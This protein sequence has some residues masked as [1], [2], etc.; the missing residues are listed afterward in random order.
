MEGKVARFTISPS[1]ADSPDLAECG[2]SA[3]V[4][5][6]KK[7]DASLLFKPIAAAPLTLNSVNAVASAS[8]A[9]PGSSSPTPM[10]LSGKELEE[11]TMK[12]VTATTTTTTAATATATT[13]TT[14]VPGM[15]VENPE[16]ANKADDESDDDEAE[17]VEESPTGRW[18][19]RKEQIKY[20][21]VPGI[22]TAYL[23][24]DSEEGFEVVWNE[25]QFSTAKKFASQE[26]KLKGV[27]EA[28][29]LIDHPNIVRFHNYWIDKGN[30]NE[31][32]A[33]RLVFITEYMSSGSL[34]NFLRKTKKNNRKIALQS[35]KRWCTQILSALSYLHQTCTPPIIHG[36]LTCDT[37]FIQHNGLVKIGS[38]APDI[39]H[40][41]VKTCRE[42]IK[43]LHYLAPE[44]GEEGVIPDTASDIYSFG[45]CALET[46]ALDIQPSTPQVTSSNAASSATSAGGSN[47]STNIQGASTTSNPSSG[48][49]TSASTIGLS[50]KVE[51]KEPPPK[52]AN[53]SGSSGTTSENHGA[54]TG[55]VITEEM[56]FRAIDHL[57]DEMQKDFI[58]KCMNKDP[59]A[60][61]T[62]RDL[63]FHPVLF[64]VHSLK[65]LAAHSLVNAPGNIN[66][67]MDDDATKAHYSSQTVKAA[68]LKSGEQKEFKL[69]DFPVAEKLEKFMEDVKNGI[70]PI[71][72]FPLLQGASAAPKTRACSPENV[73]DEKRNLGTPEPE[74]G[75]VNNPKMLNQI[76]VAVGFGDNEGVDP[77]KFHVVCVGKCEDGIFRQVHAPLDFSIHTPGVLAEE[78]IAQRYYVL[79]NVGALSA[80]FA[81]GIRRFAQLVATLALGE[82][83]EIE[84][85][86][87]GEEVLELRTQE[88]YRAI[89]NGFTWYDTDHPEQTKREEAY[90]PEFVKNHRDAFNITL[91][92][93]MPEGMQWLPPFTEDAE[94]LMQQNEVPQN[95][96]A[97][98][99][100]HLSE[101]Q[102]YEMI[103]QNYGFVPYGAR[104]L[105]PPNNDD[106]APS[107]TPQ[108]T[109][110]DRTSD[111]SRVKISIS[112]TNSWRSSP[113]L[114]ICAGEAPF[115]ELILL[116]PLSESRISM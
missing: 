22:D 17:I 50:E 21:D 57:D 18:L 38:I 42:N 37:I 41:N 40:Q 98:D 62:A 95:I 111:N 47:T 68:V 94:F 8:T 51:G 45:V 87:F 32:K 48:S 19:K 79:D 2:A 65:L 88:Q 91:Q 116:F 71:T 60:R 72:A 23:A 55:G 54:T 108:N 90:D 13:T 97:F 78:L 86:E 67:T 34:K 59:K 113:C 109:D 85:G 36:N 20:R 58:R 53:P 10:A 93:P 6:E 106:S 56:L 99:Y 49:S 27:F 12:Q 75:E 92:Y 84:E 15:G 3:P 104:N 105:P 61:P 11:E 70:Y 76:L 35:W 63:L 39:I 89:L 25:A 80:A 73:V 81:D 69:S 102:L 24:M 26:E 52:G 64:E 83:P 101:D 66:E 100:R 107:F 96:N 114:I 31:K 46:A 30:P 82:P 44:W 5:P 74:K 29:T 43:N 110:S 4:G 103:E 9:A 7:E 14:T 112:S 33:P 77:L 1:G 16:D 115:L 28:L